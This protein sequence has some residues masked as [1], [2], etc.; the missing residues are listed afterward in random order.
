MTEWEYEDSRL[1]QKMIM[2]PAAAG[3]THKIILNNKSYINTTLATTLY[4]GSYERDR[5][6][7]ALVLRDNQFIDVTEGRY[8]FKIFLNHKFGVRH[9]N[10]TGFTYNYM[11][12]NIDLQA[13]P[14]FND[15]M[16]QYVKDDGISALFQIYTQSKINITENLVLNIGLH[17]Q[18]FQLN[19][20]YTIEPRAGLKW[21]FN[22][23]QAIS[24]GYGMHSKLEGLKLYLA[25]QESA[26]GTRYPNKNLDF[27]KANHFILGYDY[28]INNN[29][30]LKVEPYFQLLENVPV[31]PDS[32][33]SMIN[34]TQEW[35][36]SDSLANDGKGTNIGIDI[37][38]ERFLDNNY[39]WLVTGSFYESKYTGGDGIERNS[40]YDRTYMLNGLFGKEFFVGK[41]GKNNILGVS[42]KATLQGGDRKSPVIY[43]ESIA[44]QEVI[45]DESRAYSVKNPASFYI[46]FTITYKKNKPKY[47]STWALQIKNLLMSPTA[48]EDEYNY[49]TNDIDEFNMGAVIP[50]LSYKVEF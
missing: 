6:D 48:F 49:K 33:Y 11:Y 41:N 1:N 23:K 28:V 36:F 42:A 16:V 10:R 35:F 50:S 5:L 34:Y 17:S 26:N 43:N 38:V 8:I 4:T 12:Y 2:I 20:N 22:A 32:S 3:F 31:I 39:F 37:T 40:K 30:R 47:T 7:D 21:N 18:Y 9:T 44:R 25:R 29:L 15:P 45:Y 14:N 19:N 24:F 13:S 46:D 27:S